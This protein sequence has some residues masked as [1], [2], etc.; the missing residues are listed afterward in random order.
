[1]LSLHLLKDEEVVPGGVVLNGG[2]TVRDGIVHGKLQRVP[3]FLAAGRRNFAVDQID[4]RFTHDA[5]RFAPCVP[6]NLSARWI[7][8]FRCDSSQPQGL[9]VG[10]CDMAI[11]TSK[12][13]RVAAGDRIEILPR[14]KLLRRPKRVIPA[15]STQP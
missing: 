3:A 13:S 11:D 9:A 7:G 15:A 14:G 10:D 2:N 12:N 1:M 8:C 6:V 5:C 4:C